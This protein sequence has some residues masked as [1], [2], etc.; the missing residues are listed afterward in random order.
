M[1]CERLYY[2]KTYALLLE[3]P[4]VLAPVGPWALPNFCE[5]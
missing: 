3:S 5:R 4:P 1:E 2:P